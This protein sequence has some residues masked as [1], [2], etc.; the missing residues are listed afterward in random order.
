MINFSL[1]LDQ[2]NLIMKHLGNGAYT[3]VSALIAELQRQSIR[4]R[5]R[6]DVQCEGRGYP[7]QSDIGT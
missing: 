5:G 4:H 7:G 6:G 1:T 2:A 3:D